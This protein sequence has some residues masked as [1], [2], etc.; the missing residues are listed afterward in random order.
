MMMSEWSHRCVTL[1]RS[2]IL[3]LFAT[4]VTISYSWTLWRWSRLV[5]DFS[6]DFSSLLYGIQPANE[7]KA[8]LCCVSVTGPELDEVMTFL[9][10]F[11]ASISSLAQFC[12]PDCSHLL[13]VFTYAPPPPVSHSQWALFSNTHTYMFSS[14]FC[15]VLFLRR[16]FLFLYFVTFCSLAST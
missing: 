13:T 16:V 12:F 10:Y 2:R 15:H 4:M 7:K 6:V 5:L 1:T 9:V 14:F 8:S 11:Q 3:M